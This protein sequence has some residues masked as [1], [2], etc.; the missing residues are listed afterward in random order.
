[1]KADVKYRRLPVR[2]NHNCFGCSPTNS[3]GLKM[4]FVT[5]GQA[6]YSRLA[7]PDHLCGWGN[8]VHGGILCTVL[9]EVMGWTAIHLLKRFAIT[10][11]I[12]VEFLRPVYVGEELTAEGRLA[13]IKGP[14]LAEIRGVITNSKGRICSKAKAIFGLYTADEIR[15]LRVMEERILRSVEHL[16]ED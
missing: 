16:L 14:R 11:S 9:D 12:A 2:G 10:K 6:V 3:A 1:M 4:R 8:V 15:K 7:I 5:D 13:E